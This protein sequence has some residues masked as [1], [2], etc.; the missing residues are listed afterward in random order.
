VFHK[1]KIGQPV[2]Y[3]PPPSVA[4][5][6]TDHVTALLPERNGEFEYRVRHPDEEHERVVR[7]SELQERS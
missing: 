2:G 3:W 7:E 5:Q 4:P 6:G 1:F